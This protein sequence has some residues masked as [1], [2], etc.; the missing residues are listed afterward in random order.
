MTLFFIYFLNSVYDIQFCIWKTSKFVFMGSCFGPFW[1][2]KY[3]NFDSGNMI[4][5]ESE[6]PGFTFSIELKTKFVLSH[7]QF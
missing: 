4:I 7:G 3:P 6:E 5:R 1:S 2:A